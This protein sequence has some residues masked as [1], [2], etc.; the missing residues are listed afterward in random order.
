MLTRC[1]RD[2]DAVYRLGG[3]EFLIV[4]PDAGETPAVRISERIRATVKTLEFE[5]VPAKEQITL[6]I[7]VNAAVGRLGARVRAGARVHRRGDVR[8]QARGS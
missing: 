5:H 8:V 7:G 1:V 2:D 6:S 3:E 4:L